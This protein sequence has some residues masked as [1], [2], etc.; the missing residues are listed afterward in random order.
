MYLKKSTLAAE[1]DI[2]VRPVETL[3]QLIRKEI[4]KRYPPGCCIHTGYII[5]VRDDV[6]EDCFLNRREIE[7]GT[8]P[9]FVPHER[10]AWKE[11]AL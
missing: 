8:A 1:Y 11:P 4:G 3:I 9:E 6:F 7:A 2:S 10:H 5:R